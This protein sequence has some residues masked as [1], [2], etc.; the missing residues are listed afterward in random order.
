M[1]WTAI[2]GICNSL[3]VNPAHCEWKVFSR[4]LLLLGSAAKFDV[5]WTITTSLQERSRNNEIGCE[6]L[7]PKAKLMPHLAIWWKA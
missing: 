4:S 6:R 5:L 1:L 7:G 3:L 2:A